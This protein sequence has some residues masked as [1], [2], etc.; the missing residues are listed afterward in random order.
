M[1]FGSD[2]QTVLVGGAGLVVGTVSSSGEPRAH[3]AWSAVVTDPL[4]RRVRFVMSADD[5]DL[6]AHLGSGA[7]SL[8]GADV[9]TYQSVQLKGRPVCV[10]APTADDLQ[11]ARQHSDA[12]F[13]AV[14][15]IDGNPLELLRRML[16]LQMMAVEM[17]VEE[18]FDQTPGPKAG[19]PLAA[20]PTSPPDRSAS[21]PSG[22]T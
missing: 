11:T 4:E 5:P 7:V 8:T 9:A 6:V 15:R 12:F 13:D 17:I 19:T 21:K 16:P 3:R 20:V 1:D 2:L 22:P 10:E 14:H 18:T